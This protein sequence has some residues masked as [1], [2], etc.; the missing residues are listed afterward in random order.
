[1]STKRGWV[2]RGLRRAGRFVAAAGLLAASA[3]ALLLGLLWVDHRQ[4][5]LLPEPTGPFAVGRTFRAWVR[6]EMPDRRTSLPGEGREVL[7]WIWYPA[8][9]GLPAPGRADYLPPRWREAVERQRGVLMTRF[10]TRDL[11]RVRAH[12]LAEAELSPARAAYPV[13]LIRAGLSALTTNYTAL[14][15]DLASHG[16]V[17]VGIDAPFRTSVV[18]LPDGR[19]IPRAPRYNADLVGGAERSGLPPTWSGRGART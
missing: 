17:V 11:S 19:V 2:C 6:Q 15:E 8:A 5:T 3:I 16:Y 13:V 14:A 7:A 4:E 9:P 10:L 18:V 1:M 12:S